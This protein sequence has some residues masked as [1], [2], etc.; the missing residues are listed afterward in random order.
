MEEYKK[1]LQF[2][3]EQAK[4]TVGML[5][6][7][8]EVLEKEK[9]LSP[10]LYKALAKEIIYESSRNLKNLIEIYLKVGSITFKTKPRE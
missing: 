8:I 9:V 5:C 4:A 10:S 3:D 6:K 7:R 1:I 2:V